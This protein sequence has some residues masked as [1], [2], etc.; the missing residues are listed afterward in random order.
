MA[1]LHPDDEAFA[2]QEILSHASISALFDEHLG[3]RPTSIISPESQGS[4]H[5]VYF[6]SLC[7]ADGNP[8]SSRDV[9][10]RV[11]R[12]T[13]VK[14]KTENEMA[15]LKLLRASG[16]PVPE[17]VFFCSDPDNPLKYEYN[18]LERVRYPSLEEIWPTLSPAQL[19]RVL[20]QFVDIFI[21]LF[22]T[23]VPPNHG[24]LALD[25][26]PG[27]VIEETMWQLPDIQRYFHADPYNLTD[28]TFASINP[29]EPG[30]TSW[31]AYVSAF[32]KKYHH[33]ISIHPA[34]DFLRDLLEPLQG[35][36]TTLDAAEAPWVRRL[37]DEPALRGRLFHRDVHFGNILADRDG[38]IKAIIDWEFAGIGASFA[39]RSSLISNCVGYLRYKYS[40]NVPDGAQVIIDTWEAEFLSRLAERAPII[41]TTWKHET[42]QDA[43]LG[44]EGQALSNI[45]EYLRSCL[46]VGVRGAGR[47]EMARGSWKTVV[48]ENLK[49]L[50]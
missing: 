38:T 36:I 14:V 15:L 31:P 11:A 50:T 32:L 10:L 41:A 16:I 21:R 33:V 19:D 45:R 25:G 40:P 34:V 37:R 17:V 49:I 4:F 24:S 47:V 43:V 29:T 18:C 46:E 12:K 8:W 7:E 5:K 13:I 48:E 42:D 2:K 6:V 26:N 9:V 35:L 23:S 22:S 1:T 27:P 3:L 44:V 39:S 28:E 20:D 30:Y